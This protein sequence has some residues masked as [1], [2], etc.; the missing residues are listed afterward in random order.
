MLRDNVFLGTENENDRVEADSC[1]YCT[2][3]HSGA[4]RHLASAWSNIRRH[5]R[6]LRD[7]LRRIKG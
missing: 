6:N 7:K 1:V 2:L 3:D 4:E 5:R